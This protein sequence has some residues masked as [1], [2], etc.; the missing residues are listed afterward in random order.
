[1]A[2][3]LT[4]LVETDF[5]VGFLGLVLFGGLFCFVGFFFSDYTDLQP[6]KSY[7]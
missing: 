5:W 6:W 3:K 4:R 7:N 1:M 2:T